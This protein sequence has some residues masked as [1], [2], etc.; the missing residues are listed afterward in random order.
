MNYEIYIFSKLGLDFYK[1]KLCIYDIDGNLI[2]NDRNIFWDISLYKLLR[3]ST[4]NYI[5]S[6]SERNSDIYKI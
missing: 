4:K 2:F 5:I 6:M 3:I 1:Y